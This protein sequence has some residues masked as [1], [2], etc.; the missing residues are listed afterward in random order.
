MFRKKEDEEG[1]AR[2]AVWAVRN[3]SRALRNEIAR[4]WRRG[5]DLPDA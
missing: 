2:L 4:Q 3:R 1:L 5:L